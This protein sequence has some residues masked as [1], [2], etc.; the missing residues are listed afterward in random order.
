MTLEERFE[1]KYIP[2]PNSG[3]WLWL[4]ALDTSGYG[5][6]N[7]A[8]RILGAHRVSWEL[9]QGSIPEGKNVLH[10]CDIPSCVNPNHLYIGTQKDN[11]KDMHDRGRDWQSQRTHCPR[12]HAYVE[13]N[14]IWYNGSRTCRICNGMSSREYQRLKRSLR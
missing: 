10:T 7:M 12:G 9:H 6:F 4:A 3:C 13:S 11:A 14:I 1:E 8:G 2:E 5:K